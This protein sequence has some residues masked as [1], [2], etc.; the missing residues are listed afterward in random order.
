MT[1]LTLLG[2]TL[3]LGGIAYFVGKSFAAETKKY[4][5]T[6]AGNVLF[7]VALSAFGAG[8]VIAF[9]SIPRRY[10]EADPANALLGLLLL[11]G[12]LAL[13]WLATRFRRL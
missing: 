3:L 2:A 5:L 6:P 9:T 7:W 1:F 8:L 11:S 12:G 10:R 13:L 4:D